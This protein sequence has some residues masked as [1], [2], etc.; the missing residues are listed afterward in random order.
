MRFAFPRNRR[1]LLTLWPSPPATRQLESCGV[2][3]QKFCKKGIELVGHDLSFF[4][5]QPTEGAQ[6]GDC[7]PKGT[8]DKGDEKEEWLAWLGE[9]GQRLKEPIRDGAANDFKSVDGGNAGAE[10][11]ERTEAALGLPVRVLQASA[12]G[13]GSAD[14]SSADRGGQEPGRPAPGSPRPTVP[15]LRR[16]FRNRSNQAK[17][18]AC[19][20]LSNL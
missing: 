19:I 5:T 18:S 1:R 8:C 17:A 20:V 6:G 11:S 12:G 15:W 4:K 14:A 9:N 16:H 10:K 13:W 7:D 2:K 3:L